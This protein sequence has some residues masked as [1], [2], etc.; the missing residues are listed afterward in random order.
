MFY[1]QKARHGRNHTH[2]FHDHTTMTASTEKRT[3]PCKT[4]PWCL[5]S[6]TAAEYGDIHG[7][8]AK[9]ERHKKNSNSSTRTAIP[10]DTAGYTPLHLAAQHGHVAATAMLLQQQQFVSVVN[11]S[12]TICTLDSSLYLSTP[13]HRA[14]FTGAVATMQLL[15]DAGSTVTDL[16]A[17]DRSFGDL[18]TPLHK[19][20]AGGRY[21]AVQLLL[22]ALDKNSTTTTKQ[23]A[24]SCQDAQGQTPLQVA[25]EL[26]GRQEEE[27]LSVRRWDAVAGG[28]ADWN[29]CVELLE[30]QQQ[31]QDVTTTVQQQP[32][33]SGPRHLSS[34]Q[35]CLDC[36]GDGPCKTATWEAAFRSVLAKSVQQT[37]SLAAPNKANGN[38]DTCDVAVT[39]TTC[40]SSKAS[41]TAS[42]SNSCGR[43]NC[44]GHCTVTTVQQDTDTTMNDVSKESEKR[45]TTPTL[46]AGRACGLCNQPS[47]VLFRNKKGI[48]VCKSCQKPSKSRYRSAGRYR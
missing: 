48:L 33:L 6:F 12:D 38:K 2:I 40:A 29:K 42:T 21:M 31:Q 11:T 46:P 16:M 4:L 5:S 14:S 20:V 10:V 41:D 35:N 34:L 36:N 8:A 37:L 7:L 27:A 3:C 32:A 39:T 45:K 28:P 23:Q 1:E 15:I 19:A 44:N 26:R 18:R 17:R 24:L 43:S 25:Y 9:L 13:L 30:Q 22:T 47:F